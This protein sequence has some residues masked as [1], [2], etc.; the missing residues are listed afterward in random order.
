MFILKKQW[1]TVLI[2][3]LVLIVVVFAVLN[4]DPVNINVGFATFDIPLVLVI[5]G[6]LLIGVLITVMGSTTIL[7]REKNKIKKMDRMLEQEKTKASDEQENL[8]TKYQNEKTTLE[9]Q[10]EE[11]K[12]HLHSLIEERETEINHLNRKIANL[13]MGRQLNKNDLSKSL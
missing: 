9:K 8:K 4:V 12:E 1:S 7:F 10:Y 6:T 11:E 2:I 13:E 5:I 3:A